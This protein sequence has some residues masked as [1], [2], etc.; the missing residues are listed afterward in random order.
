MVEIAAGRVFA[1][2]LTGFA[3]DEGVDASQEE[4]SS[5]NGLVSSRVTSVGFD[6]AALAM[7]AGLED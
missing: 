4:S 3:A 1:G 2:A 5:S 6:C 7:G